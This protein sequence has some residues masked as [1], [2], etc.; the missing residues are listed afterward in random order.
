MLGN[1]RAPAQLQ[2]SRL[3]YCSFTDFSE[4]YIVGLLR[5]PICFCFKGAYCLLQIGTDF[6]FSGQ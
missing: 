5:D 4:Y 1:P 6:L 2:L 3:Y